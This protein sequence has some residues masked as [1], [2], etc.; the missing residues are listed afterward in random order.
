MHL[1]STPVWLKYVTTLSST[2]KYSLMKR[3]SLGH[4]YCFEV[5]LPYAK[6]GQIELA[7][8]NQAGGN[9]LYWS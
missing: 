6:C 5:F 1:K 9:G 2:P 4:P 3:Y 8:Q 7:Y